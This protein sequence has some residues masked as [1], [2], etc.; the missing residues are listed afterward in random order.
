M[1]GPGAQGTTSETGIACPGRHCGRAAGPVTRLIAVTAALTVTVSVVTLPALSVATN[2]NGGALHF[3]PDGQLYVAVGDNANGA[4]AQSLST[5]LGKMLRIDVNVAD[6]DPFGYTVPPNAVPPGSEGTDFTERN[7]RKAILIGEQLRA[8][9]ER[10]DVGEVT[11]TDVAQAQAGM[12]WSKAS[13]RRCRRRATAP[14]RHS[15][16]SPDQSDP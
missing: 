15:A 16:R 4:N 14:G 12:G 7:F 9:Q 6:S 2:H 10:F 13:A 1:T 3:G 8:T 11:R 5:R